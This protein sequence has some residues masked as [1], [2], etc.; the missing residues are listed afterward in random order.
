MGGTV[1]DVLH[2][3]HPGVRQLAETIARAFRLEIMAIDYLS[4]D[5]GRPPD[6]AGGVVCEV[7]QSPGLRPHADPP[8][9]RERIV[10]ML[11]DRHFP[12]GE[13][14]RIPVALVAGGSGRIA[15]ARMLAAMLEASGKV[16]GLAVP[17]TISVGGRV[18]R[19]SGS[20]EDDLVRNVLFDPTAEAAVLAVGAGAIR[21]EGLPVDRADAVAVLDV[22]GEEDVATDEEMA[23]IQAVVVGA[24]TRVVVLDADDAACAALAGHAAAPVIWTSL[25]PDNAAVA[26]HVRAGGAA[27]HVDGAGAVVVSGLGGRVVVATDADIRSAIGGE[28][29]PLRSALAAVALAHG[30]GLSRDAVAA[31]L[32]AAGA[33]P[34]RAPAAEV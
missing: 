34:T 3:V 32:A 22:R 21:R 14:G 12:P 28:T 27:A 15:T 16:T 33:A 1:E 24:A 29:A 2:R 19:H 17:P 18:F 6:E 13:D 4:A 23:R 7:N 30:L 9:I 26:A 31:G 25:R 5:I 10:D 8:E 20:G 11:L